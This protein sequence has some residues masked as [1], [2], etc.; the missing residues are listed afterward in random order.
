MKNYIQKINLYHSLLFFLFVN[1]FSLIVDQNKNLIIS[2]VFCLFLILTIG[3]SH[4]SLDYIKGQKLMKTQKIISI[5]LFFLVY[6]LIG[7]IVIILWLIF[8]AV[9]LII[10]LLVA[11]YHFGKED[12]EF[13]TNKNL[14]SNQ[15]LFFLKGLL[16]IIAPL[17]FH[18]EETINIFKLLFV[19]NEKF[20]IFLGFIEN[21]KILPII[22]LLSMLS[23]IILF[24]KNFKFV[25]FS[26]FFDFFSILI[27]NYY[28][29]PVIAFTFYFCFLHSIR[30]SFSL[31]F[32]LDSSNFK[33]GFLI[34]L[35]KAIPLT[36][37]TAVIY[38]ITLFFLNNYYE[39]ND[40][41]LKVIFIGLASLTFPHILLEYLLEKN[42][43]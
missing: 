37:L 23:S 21:N 42:E 12:S 10:F 19:E 2:H 14:I 29:S 40:S 9:S 33:N 22:F 6:I 7:L 30:H 11:S 38:I 15:L 8:P 20:Y 4:G 28:L 43:K 25:S 26:I 3:I 31:M 17:Q 1:I 34:F 35:K 41:I 36:V 16:I 18:F 5:Y 13:L 39:F 27:L 32:Q 24:I